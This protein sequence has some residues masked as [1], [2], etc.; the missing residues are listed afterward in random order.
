M[1][2]LWVRISLTFTFIVVLI[3]GVPIVLFAVYYTYDIGNSGIFPNIEEEFTDGKVPL[4]GEAE[5]DADPGKAISQTMIRVL[6]ATI[7]F[8]SIIGI[9]TARS[10]TAPLN[11]LADAA[12][13]IG[14]QDLKRRVEVKGSDEIIAVARAFNDMAAG[15][16]KAETLRTTLLNDVAHELHTPLSVI[17]GNLSAILDDVF[18][19]D[20]AEVAHIYEQTLHLSRIVDDLRDLA[21]AEAKRLALNLTELDVVTWVRETEAVFRPITKEKG[22]TLRV[23]ILGEHPRIQ[24]DKA[25]LTQA[26][27]NLLNNAIQHTPTGVIITVQV[28]QRQ[29]R[30][31]LRVQDTGVGIAPEHLSHIFDRFYRADSARSRYVGRTGLGL[32]I[33]RAI[34]EAHGGE[35]MA[36]CEGIGRGSTFSIRLPI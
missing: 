36:A 5:F 22:V 33:V 4:Y 24:A 30:L 6:A 1:N 34:V 11:E 17:Q 19:M 21:Q 32:P 28:E 20:K 27:L 8:G 18:Q 25:R 14:S 31:W 9:I 15:L 35:V 10:L 29:D 3:I 2:R 12:E 7:T 26:L 16:E 23:E 13:A